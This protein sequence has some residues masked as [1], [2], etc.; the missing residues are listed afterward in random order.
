[1][2]SFPDGKVAMVT[3]SSKG[4]S[5]V[6]YKDETLESLMAKF[7][8]TECDKYFAFDNDKLLGLKSE[9]GFRILNLQRVLTGESEEPEIE[10]EVH[11]SEIRTPA[12]PLPLS[13]KDVLLET[14]IF[15]TILAVNSRLN[16]DTARVILD[17]I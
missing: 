12:F 5:V 3:K 8:D 15:I 14:K 16:N 10:C 6:V 2:I 7:P 17:F 11:N 1:M 9:S 4:C 13:S